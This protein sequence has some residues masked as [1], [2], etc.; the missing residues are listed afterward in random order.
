VFDGSVMYIA[1]FGL[2]VPSEGA[3]MNGR[4]LRVDVGV[5]GMPLYK[6]RIG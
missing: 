6:G 5:Q 2:T 3:P 4:L 1:D